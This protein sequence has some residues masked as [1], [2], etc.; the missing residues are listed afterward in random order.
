MLCALCTRPWPDDKCVVVDLTPEETAHLAALG[1]MGT[2]QLVYCGPCHRVLADP[3]RGAQLIKG[4]LMLQLRAM[5]IPNAEQVA[6]NFAKK[7]LALA[8]KKRS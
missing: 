8:T 5:G 7:L 1:Q 6:D 2:T 3:V 4:T